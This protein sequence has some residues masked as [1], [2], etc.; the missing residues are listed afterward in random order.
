MKLYSL[1]PLN[2]I[3]QYANSLMLITGNIREIYISILIPNFSLAACNA[4]QLVNILGSLFVNDVKNVT[5]F[6]IYAEI[7]IYRIKL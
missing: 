7:T 2:N 4:L 5:I 3:G 1:H 6:R